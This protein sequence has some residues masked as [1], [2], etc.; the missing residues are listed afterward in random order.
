MRRGLAAAADGEAEEAH[1][2][3]H[4]VG[5]LGGGGVEIH[6]W[7]WGDAGDGL[8]FGGVSGGGGCSEGKGGEQ[9]DGFHGQRWGGGRM[10]V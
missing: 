7:R 9:E 6:L 10:R 3:E 5:R 8:R 1:H 4:G 2:E